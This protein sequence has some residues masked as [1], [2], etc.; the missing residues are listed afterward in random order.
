[1]LLDFATRLLSVMVFIVSLTMGVPA[2][3]QIQP[4]NLI[5]QN[6][7][8]AILQALDAHDIVGFG[9]SHISENEHRVI[10]SL[11]QDPR[12]PTKVNDLIVEFGNSRYQSIVDRYVSGEKVS[13][14]EL[15]IVWRNALFF[16]VWDRP[17]Y[18]RVFKTVR[19]I[20]QTLPRE[21]RIRILLV[22][23]PFD[24]SEVT[25]SAK[26]ND[27]DL[28]RDNCYVDRIESEVISRGH[29]AVAIF[30]ALHFLRNPYWSGEA[31]PR[32]P[33]KTALVTARQ[34]RLGQLLEKRHPG[35]L[36]FVWAN[37]LSMQD[38]SAE[39]ALASLPVPSLISL[40][41]TWL[42]KVD[43]RAF[44]RYEARDLDP[45]TW[46]KQPLESVADACIYLGPGKDQVLSEPSIT[47]YRDQLWIDEM[48]SR[49]RRLGELGRAYLDAIDAVRTK[50]GD[51]DKQHT[52]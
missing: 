19:E 22:E 37:C 5:P 4:G 3:P 33:Q 7:V 50:Y 15:R 25:S 12:F 6:P 35:S 23:Q 16:M 31:V 14:S 43:F 52:P 8:D 34:V 28:Q 10:Q 27:L 40:K 38:R 30:G 29:K 47:S 51:N 48:T 18:E 24:W 9:E 2:Q 13:E 17:V 11:L 41:G 45:S 46:K 36:Y 49:S 32:D 44:L 39:K 26:F 20:N 21:R 42:G 1:M